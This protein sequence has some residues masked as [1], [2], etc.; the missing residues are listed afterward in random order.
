MGWGG[1][2]RSG[3]SKVGMG[4]GVEL[5]LVGGVGSEVCSCCGLAWDEEVGPPHRSVS[6]CK[7]IPAPAPPP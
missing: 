7:N 1:A 6:E 3:L 4:C 2:V 5:V